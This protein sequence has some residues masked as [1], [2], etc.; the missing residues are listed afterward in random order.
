M[1]NT[2]AGESNAKVDCS[3]SIT[4]DSF[5]PAS[6]K[7]IWKGTLEIYS[8]LTKTTE[9]TMELH[10]LPMDSSDNYT[11]NIIYGEDKKEGLRSYELVT[12]DKEKGFY[13]IDEKNSIK[14]ET[15]LVANKFTSVFE[16]SG[17]LIIV[18][19]QKEGD[20]LIYEI[21]GGK[22]KPVSVT[23]DTIFNGEEIPI[24]K[25][26]PINNIQRAILTRN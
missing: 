17:S 1:P 6:W 24:V 26:F 2:I 21:I 23:G 8:G 12:I 19:V 5:F 16:V 25:T 22:S 13:L 15:Y 14:I 4:Q 3:I 20:H 10:I 18:T 9:L 11:W 7:G